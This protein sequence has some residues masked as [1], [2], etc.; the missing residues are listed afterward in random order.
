MTEERLVAVTAL[1][2]R[3]EGKCGGRVCAYDPMCRSIPVLV[4]DPGL[5]PE[6]ISS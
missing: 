1:R 4:I 6:A 5:F 3:G 2:A